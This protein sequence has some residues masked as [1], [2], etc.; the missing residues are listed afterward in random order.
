MADPSADDDEP[1][2][3]AGGAG[4]ALVPVAEGPSQPGLHPQGGARPPFAVWLR[5]WRRTRDLSQHQAAELLGYSRN[6]WVRLESGDRPPTTE[7]LTRLAP[8]TG[9]STQALAVVAGTA[10]EAPPVAEPGQPSGAPGGPAGYPPYPEYPSYPPPFPPYPA[11]PPYPRYPEYPDRR[12][13]GHPKH[14]PRPPKRRPGKQNV[15]PLC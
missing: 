6:Y 15:S 7:F 5:R 10:L 8:H 9:L 14:R 2:E 11:Y 3:G 4:G 1:D 12:R 13:N